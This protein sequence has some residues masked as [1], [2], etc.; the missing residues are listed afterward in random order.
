[1][2][3]SHIFSSEVQVHLFDF[4]FSDAILTLLIIFLKVDIV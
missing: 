4:S 2:E 3:W 1:M